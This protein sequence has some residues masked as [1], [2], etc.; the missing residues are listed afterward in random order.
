MFRLRS[1]VIVLRFAAAAVFPLSAFGAAIP[2]SPALS[3]QE[4]G[5]RAA[6][7]A[8]AA[9]ICK[10]APA[11][12]A[13]ARELDAAYKSVL[14]SATECDR[15]SCTLEAIQALATMIGALDKRDAALPLPAEDKP[16]RAFLAISVIATSRLT[17]A[18]TRLGKPHSGSPYSD[19][20]RTRAQKGLAGYCLASPP[21][22]AAMRALVDDGTSLGDKIKACAASKCGLEAA[23]PLV[24]G[25]HGMFGRFFP[26][27]NLATADT[28]G[29]FILLNGANTEG[30]ALYSPLADG[31]V[32][33]LVAGTDKLKRNLDLAQK[34]PAVPLTAVEDAGAPLLEKHRLAARA[35]D[36][37]SMFLGYA[38]PKNGAEARREKVNVA[39]I[40]LSGLRA[41]A[42]AL[43][44][45]R[46]LGED[47]AGPGAVSAAGGT[48]P[49][50]ARPSGVVMT[51]A[52]RTILDRR[53]VPSPQGPK[54]EAPPILHGDRRMAHNFFYANSKDPVKRADALRRLNKTKTVGD[55]GR[56]APHAFTQEGDD[57]CAVAAQVAVL[58]AHGLLPSSVDPNIQERALVSEAK[59][60]G[61]MKSGTAPS[62]TGSLLIERGM[63]LDKH[64]KGTWAKLE[65]ALRRGGIIQASVDARRLWSVEAPKPLPHSILVTGTEISKKGGEILGVYINDTG[66]DPPGAGKFVPI[67]QFQAAWFG[68]FAEI[69]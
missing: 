54:A 11:S 69:R 30:I 17:A 23:D 19:D 26:L 24:T 14:A 44:A 9:D 33:E 22:C 38:E 41:R 8:Y 61:Y 66:T 6:A 52:P 43:R 60:L 2:P 36:R 16:D 32:A 67:A 42:F 63:L 31:A 10:R 35:A 7:E 28:I 49:G 34:N 48:A 56:Y 55:P 13:E 5:A 65:S 37:L 40:K 18:A 64:P 59:G 20:A 58:R 21:N 51:E 15:G 12:C 68:S 29:I 47:K 1:L 27:D 53:L 25:A 4:P 46:G 45:A 39:A 50:A 62:Y 57:S 3:L